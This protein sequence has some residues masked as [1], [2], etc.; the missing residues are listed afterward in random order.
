MSTKICLWLMG[1]ILKETMPF[2]STKRSPIGLVEEL[3][4]TRKIENP[5]DHMNSMNGRVAQ[6]MKMRYSF[7]KERAGE[8]AVK[9]GQKSDKGRLCQTLL[10]SF[11]KFFYLDIC[12]S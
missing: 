1:L 6:L 7:L 2:I 9:N 8:R 12:S 4:I 10:N 11:N 3:C 5:K